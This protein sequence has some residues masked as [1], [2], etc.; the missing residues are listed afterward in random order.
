MDYN[1]ISRHLDVAAEKL[2]RKGYSDLADKIDQC[3]KRLAT[4]KTTRVKKLIANTIGKV[5][6]EAD[7]RDRAAKPGSDTNRVNSR[8]RRTSTRG[9]SDSSKRLRRSRIRAALLRRMK[10]RKNANRSRINTSSS[11]VQ[12]AIIVGGKTYVLQSA[13]T[14]KN[15]P[16]DRRLASKRQIARRRASRR[17][18]ART[19][20]RNIRRNRS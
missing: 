11:A 6:R 8:R 19:R 3:N 4:A 5:D 10:D 15:S 18:A 7:R 16:K 14:A 13:E 17:A 1:K 9:R 2:D 12:R 20:G